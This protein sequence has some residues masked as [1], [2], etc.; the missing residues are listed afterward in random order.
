MIDFAIPAE[1][2]ELRDRTA[3]F[4]RDQIIPLEA[5]APTDHHGPTEQFRLELVALAR[6]EG[7]VAPHVSKEFG[8]LGLS[9]VAKAFVFEESGYSLLGPVAMHIAAPDEGNMHLLEVV[10]SED[11]KE[12]F[13]RP[14]ASGEQRSMFMMTE[15]EGG[16]G[17]DPSMMKTRADEQADGSYRIN[18]LKWLI[19]SALGAQVAIIMARTFDRAGTD[20]GA[21]MFLTEAD[22][23]GIAIE[24]VLETMDHN[25]VGGHAV[26][27]L[28]DVHLPASSVLGEVGAGFR[29]AQ[30]RLGPAR[31][32]HCMRW[33]GA[34]RRCHDIA[35]DYARSRQAFGKPIGEHQGIGFQIADNLTDMQTSRLLIQ[36]C[37]WMLDQGSQAREESSMAKLYVSEATSR[38][39][40]RS[41]QILG[42]RGITNRTVVRQIYEDIR[43]FRIYDGP[44]EVHRMAIARRALR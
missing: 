5:T 42:G 20:V 8:G 3:A 22:T 36:H 43:A 31:L 2:G 23:A 25:A 33:L 34:A 17:S 35:V 14:V 4:I 21:T 7:L 27:R 41:V 38:V 16:A 9:H 37:A 18:G 29:Y 10:A 30:V 40:D 1:L 32:T 28:T 26:I 12:R 13:L 24:E 19:T 11:Q 6:K 44:S 39:V 15:P